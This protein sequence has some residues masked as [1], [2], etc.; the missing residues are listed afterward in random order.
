MDIEKVIAA[1]AAAEKQG[2]TVQ[3]LGRIFK[4]LL[5]A[6]LGMILVMTVIAIFVPASPT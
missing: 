5:W 4:N 6:A 1:K 2:L 3:P